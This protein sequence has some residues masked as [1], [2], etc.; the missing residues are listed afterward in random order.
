M[1]QEQQEQ[2]DFYMAW[3]H[4]QV[5]R[6]TGAKKN[7]KQ[8]DTFEKKVLERF[9][10]YDPSVLELLL[11]KSAYSLRGAQEYSSWRLAAMKVFKNNQGNLPYREIGRFFDEQETKNPEYWREVGE[12]VADAFDSLEAH[13]GITVIQP[14]QSTATNTDQKE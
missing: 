5:D 2:D 6:V 12:I 3:V 9:K 8:V 10:G 14:N 7:T 11:N 1:T 4:R 13:S